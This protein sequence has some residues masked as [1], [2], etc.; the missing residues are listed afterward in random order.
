MVDITMGAFLL[1]SF[2]CAVPRADHVRY[3]EGVT[4]PACQSIPCEMVEKLLDEERDL[5]CQGVTFVPSNGASLF[6][7][8]TKKI[9]EASHTLFPLLAII[10]TYL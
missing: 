2:I 3:L 10:V 1:W 7:Y 8:R 4:S 5:S 6:L 9:I